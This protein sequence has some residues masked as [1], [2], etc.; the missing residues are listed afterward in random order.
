MG[1]S[2]SLSNNDEYTAPSD[3]YVY[4]NAPVYNTTGYGVVN[5]YGQ[6][7][8]AINSSPNQ[9][10]TTPNSGS[11]FVK[12]GMVFSVNLLNFNGMFYPISNS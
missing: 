9:S 2:V 1:A 8:L 3:G 4:I 12:K 6:R 5:V 10:N 7:L 11:V